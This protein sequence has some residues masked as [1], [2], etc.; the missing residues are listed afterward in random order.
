MRRLARQAPTR[1]DVS[2]AWLLAPGCEQEH[3]RAEIVGVDL[4]LH[5]VQQLVDPGV[6]SEP[7]VKPLPLQA[8]GYKGVPFGGAIGWDIFQKYH[9]LA[10]PLFSAI[11]SVQYIDNRRVLTGCKVHRFLA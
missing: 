8:W 2:L 5:L 10:Y 3:D 7:P 6:L 9:L 1:Y 4:D 11:L